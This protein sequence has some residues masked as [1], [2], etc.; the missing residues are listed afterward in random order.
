MP[1]SITL[2][3]DQKAAI[4]KAK[5]W[6][7]H[8]RE[9]QQVFRLFG[10]AGTGK[11]TVQQA[12]LD[13]L[14]IAPSQV[15]FLAPTG[16]AA[17][18]LI[19]KGH[20]AQ[21]IHKA[22]YTQTGEDD[23]VFEALEQE[24]ISIR[25]KLGFRVLENRAAYQRRLEMVEA[26]MNDAS[27]AAKPRF[28]FKGTRAIGST[29][30]IIIVDECSMILNDMYRDL[31]SLQLPLLLVGDPGQ[32]PPV[33]GPNPPPSLVTNVNAPDVML[34]KV[35]RQEG[36]STILELATMIRRHEHFGFGTAEVDNVEYADGRGCRGDIGRIFD[37]VG[38]KQPEYFDQIICG[39]NKTRFAINDFMKERHG[40]R[41]TLPVGVPNEKLIVLRNIFID[42]HFIANGAEI[43][44]EEDRTREGEI[45]P[46]HRDD[47]AIDHPII[48]TRLDGRP[49]RIEG[50]SLWKLLFD[51]EE[52]FR[53]RK[54]I[55]DIAA[56][57]LVHAQ[58]S[59]AI[60]AHKAQGS[61]WERICVFD[62]SD[63]FREQRFR[64]LYTAVTRASKEL[65]IIK[66]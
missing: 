52:E 16:K 54:R 47:R 21:T 14:D 60:T 51:G 27:S 18:V 38:V 62:E 57:P 49:T 56:K 15:L 50:A 1:K 64:W 17:A 10:Y 61:E 23:S 55:E 65:L 58:W 40:I 28:T 33:E 7:L 9:S 63:V 48:I 36:D 8:G 29:V 35:V 34:E 5:A 39:K 19:G 42:D 30:K 12:L 11:S 25:A 2:S 13:E 6:F 43:S 44:V 53:A 46:Y 24:A 4:A 41:N 26:Q 31:L 32:L 59:W 37:K 20:A 66:V 45:K 22:L 3:P